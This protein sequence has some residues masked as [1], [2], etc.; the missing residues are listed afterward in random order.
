MVIILDLLSARECG[1][2]LWLVAVA[3]ELDVSTIPL[4]W[5]LEPSLL[6]AGSPL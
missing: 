1:K 6:A 2:A 3:V 5:I 4:H